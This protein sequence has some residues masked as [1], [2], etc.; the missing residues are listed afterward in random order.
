MERRILGVAGENGG[1]NFYVGSGCGGWL[2]C[3]S[4]VWEWIVERR[5]GCGWDIVG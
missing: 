3:G 5:S 1:F 4:G 2:K